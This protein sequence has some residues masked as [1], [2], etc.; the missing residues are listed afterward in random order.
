MHHVG[1]IY[2]Y[3]MM[4]GQ[5]TLTLNLLTTTI[6]APP[7]NASKW[8]MGFNSA[9]NPFSGRF[10]IPC[11]AC[12]G[13]FF[14][15]CWHLN[16]KIPRAGLFSGMSGT[17]PSLCVLTILFYPG[18]FPFSIQRSMGSRTKHSRAHCIH[19][20]VVHMLAERWQNLSYQ[21]IATL[22]EFLRII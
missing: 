17:V 6:F 12:Q 8:Q 9:F 15:S 19:V 21:L 18:N 2:W 1:F 7:S 20:E 14:S 16:F 4:H 10:I 3:T 22:V 5:Q 11:R 13:R